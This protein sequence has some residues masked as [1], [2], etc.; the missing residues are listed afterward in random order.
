MRWI[1][2]T[3]RTRTASALLWM[4]FPCCCQTRDEGAYS[5]PHGLVKPRLCG[6]PRRDQ[7][8]QGA[9]LQ[10]PHSLKRAPREPQALARL[11]F[12]SPVQ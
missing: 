6:L 9:N 1:Y 10:K 11:G 12:H 3:L 2:S 8:F 5:G 4:A 7:P